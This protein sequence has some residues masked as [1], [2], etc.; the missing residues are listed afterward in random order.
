[1]PL[2][3]VEQIL[4]PLGAFLDREQFPVEASGPHVDAGRSVCGVD[5]GSHQRERVEP[6]FRFFSAPSAHGETRT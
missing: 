6:V 2:N 1:M 5:R 4:R 3:T